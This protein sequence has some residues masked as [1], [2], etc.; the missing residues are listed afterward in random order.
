MS[1]WGR[2]NSTVRVGRGGGGRGSGRAQ[3]R[4][5]IRLAHQLYGRSSKT[6]S[7]HAMGWVVAHAVGWDSQPENNTPGLRAGHS[8]WAVGKIQHQHICALL[9]NCVQVARPCISEEDRM[10]RKLGVRA[11]DHPHHLLVQQTIRYDS[12]PPPFCSG[13]CTTMYYDIGRYWRIGFVCS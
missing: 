5:A 1:S 10:F 13:K 3:E 2:K 8:F 7:V 12:P 4:T 6:V 11:I 9:E